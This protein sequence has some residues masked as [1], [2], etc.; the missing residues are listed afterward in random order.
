MELRTSVNMPSAQQWRSV[1]F[2]NGLFVAT[3]SGG[4]V[5]ATSTDG[6]TWTSR[7]LPG[8]GS[9]STVYSGEWSF[10]RQFQ[11]RTMHSS[12]FN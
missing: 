1:T 2:G 4:T 9:W 7:T 3:S 11:I 6:A 12:K 5:A 10:L 8:T